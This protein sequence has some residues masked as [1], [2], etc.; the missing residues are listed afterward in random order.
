VGLALSAAANTIEGSGMANLNAQEIANKQVSFSW[1]SLLGFLGG[2]AQ[3]AADIEG[4]ANL[5][6]YGMN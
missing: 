6:R 4:L 1:Q 5:P 2:V 3:T